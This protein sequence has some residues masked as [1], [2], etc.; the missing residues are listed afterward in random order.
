[1][2]Q[3]ESITSHPIDSQDVAGQQLY[4]AHPASTN[5][6]KGDEGA[7]DAACSGQQKEA[8]LQSTRPSGAD[9]SADKYSVFTDTE[10][11]LDP[12]GQI[13]QT[14][15][16]MQLVQT[17]LVVCI[18]KCQHLVS[19]LQL[20]CQ[21]ILELT[22]LPGVYRDV[23]QAAH[24]HI[25]RLNVIHSLVQFVSTAQPKV[26]L[27]VFACKPLRTKL[28]I[29]MSHLATTDNCPHPLLTHTHTLPTVNILKSRPS[30]HVNIF[31]S[32]LH[33]N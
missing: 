28:F 12:N 5:R 9:A 7:S 26:R 33:H 13:L 20:Y 15:N 30:T 29:F 32:H 14:F 23:Q 10:T 24:N 8:Q 6:R 2:P 22:A 3:V 21:H 16:I 4:H 18:H 17:W 11:R 1:M 19:L 31:T 25:M 27:L